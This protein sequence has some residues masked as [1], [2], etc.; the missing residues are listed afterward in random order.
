MS[1]RPAGYRVPSD[2]GDPY[3]TRVDKYN[4]EGPVE[5]GWRAEHA[6]RRSCTFLAK[7]ATDCFDAPSA[8][9][10]RRRI[11][12]GRLTSDAASKCLKSVSARDYCSSFRSGLLQVVLSFFRMT[13]IGGPEGWRSRTRSASW[14]A[15]SR[16]MSSASRGNNR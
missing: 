5:G 8:P 11:T 7:P 14:S 6:S 15:V 3:Q 16:L 13:P 9:S 1:R 10:R 2:A 4:V 12:D